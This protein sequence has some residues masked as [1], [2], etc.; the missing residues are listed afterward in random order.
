M[1][2]KYTKP[3]DKDEFMCPHCGGKVRHKAPYIYP[4]RSIDRKA[5]IQVVDSW[6]VPYS[7]GIFV[8][9]A[10]DVTQAE[11]DEFAKD[12]VHFPFWTPHRMGV[13]WSKC[14]WDD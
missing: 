2:I 10:D 9:A 7:T 12:K 4:T 5:R 11:V 1:T 14:T 6:N 8:L 3:S 13:L